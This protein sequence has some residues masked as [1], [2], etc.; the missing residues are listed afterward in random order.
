M[1]YCPKCGNKL[2]AE[3]IDSDNRLVCKEK[4]C[5]F[6]F[7]NNPVPV[8][9]ALVL[10]S[11]RYVIARNV[12]WPANTFSLITG[13]L[14]QDENPDVA[15]LR[16]VKEELNLEASIIRFIGHYNFSAKN[17]L[18]IAY[19]VRATGDLAT[20]HELAEIK[21]LTPDELLQYD[22]RPLSITEAIIGDWKNQAQVKSIL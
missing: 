19:E 1:K 8:V 18:I 6:V 15:V 16:E 5:A 13:Y 14:E 2:N 3:I 11:D 22:F 12:A 20:N 4:S 21:H 17:Q 7:W 10:Y 9:A